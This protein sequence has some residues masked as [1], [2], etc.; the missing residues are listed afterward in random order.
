MSFLS[1][2]S[3][4]KAIQKVIKNAE[5]TVNKTQLWVKL[6]NA[7]NIGTE[8]QDHFSL[9]ARDRIKLAEQTLA[10]T[11]YDPRKDDYNKMTEMTRTQS[12]LRGT[13][14]K[15]F[16]S[17]PRS[18]FIEVRLFDGSSIDSGYRG[19]LVEDAL[20]LAPDVVLSIE[21]F[22]TFVWINEHYLRSHLIKSVDVNTVLI[23][24]RGDTRA[25]PKAVKSLRKSYAG[26]WWHF[27]DFDPKGLQIAVS[28]MKSNV[29]IL[30]ELNALTEHIAIQPNI[31]DS[32]NYYKQQDS[33][34]HIRSLA[35]PYPQLSKWIA[36]MDENKLAVC[37]EPITSRELT[38]V[39]V[40]ISVS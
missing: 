26:A 3:A 28:D 12:S 30:P 23:V 15:V 13:N 10:Q 34:N 25:S 20:A 14:E 4:Y 29:V 31:S 8:Q 6:H 37:Q 22:D 18:P 33:L 27:G 35:M 32:S 21:N 11:G 5:Y 1:S 19:I 38:L 9:T 16:S 2:K 36:A 24:F 40:E 17:N 7:Y 39:S